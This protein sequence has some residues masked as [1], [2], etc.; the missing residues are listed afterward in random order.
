[1][2]TSSSYAGRLT[3]EGVL[4]VFL[5]EL[6]FV[7]TGLLT[8]AFLTHRLGPMRYGQLTLAL[9]IVAWVEWSVVAVFSRAAIKL[10]S[11]AEDWRPVGA[12][13]MRASLILGIA[14][15]VLLAIVAP[16]LAALLDEPRLAGLLAILA[17]DIPLFTL[18][19]AHRNVLT[20]LG[21]FSAR[22][23]SCAG[24][25]VARLLLVLL[26]VELG[27]SVTGAALASL[28]ASMAELL[29]CRCYVQ[30][31]L[32][33]R[34]PFSVRSLLSLA[35]PLF[36]IGMSLRLFEKLDLLALKALGGTP[37]QA[38]YYGAAQNL[39]L[40][41]SLFSL[42]IS[43]VLLAALGKELQSGAVGSARSLARD[44]LR[45]VVLSIPVS[46]V[47]A[48]CASELAGTIFGDRFT[49]AATPL[50]LLIFGSSAMLMISVT[51]AILTAVDRANVALALSAPLVPLAIVGHLAIVPTLGP[52]GAAL[53]TLVG[54]SLGALAQLIAVHRH[55]DIHPGLPT[56]GRVATAS[57]LALALA[58]RW[59]T[60]GASLLLVKLPAIGLIA[61]IV[62]GVLGEFSQAELAAARAL[63][64]GRSTCHRNRVQVR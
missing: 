35:T 12:V 27:L 26:L 19:Q 36:L 43:P 15:A 4:R 13:L 32:T 58:A 1:M 62:L 61:V 11:E 6:L 28:G 57:A 40:L 47:V 5:A 39:A 9:T 48:G 16:P 23:T 10:V 31:T 54:A 38:G 34:A 8:A 46:A 53:I 41:P 55:W 33:G 30:P 42:A 60:R 29:I 44:A 2:N 17:L 7:P 14:A 20:G 64:F 18:A 59:P 22:A 49:P 3:W 21:S 45:M 24:R 50:S 52:R 63:F 51:S 56:I 37:E 25:F